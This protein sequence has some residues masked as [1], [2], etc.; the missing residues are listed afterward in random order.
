MIKICMIGTGYVGLVS[1]ACLADFGHHVT[2]VDIDG[3]RIDRLEQGEIPIYEPGLKDVVQ[4]NVE[5]ERLYFTKNLAAAVKDADVVFIAVGTPSAADGSTD[6]TYV[7]EAS[8]DVAKHLAGYT[9]VVQKST[10]PVGT[11]RKVHAI[12]SESK[13]KGTEF[14]VVSNPEFL[15]EGSA[16]GDFLEP[17]RVVIGVASARSA[18]VMREVYRPLYERDT[19]IVITSLESAEMI[20]Y[21]ANAFLATKISFIN[22][23]AHICELAGAN[24]DE[25][26]KG[27]GYDPRIGNKFL[28][29]G[30]G[31]GGS[32][33]PKDVSSLIHCAREH[34]YDAPLVSAAHA[35]NYGLVDRAMEKLVR[36]LGEINGKSIGLLGLAFKPNTDDLREAPALRLVHELLKAGARVKVFDPVAMENFRKLIKAPVEY[37]RNVYEMAEG[38]DALMLVTEWNQFREMDFARLKQAMR[39]DVFIDCRNVYTP[40]R[41]AAR[42]FKYDSFGRGQS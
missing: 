23:M 4:R 34:G 19:P 30:I 28:H 32:C 27:M 38:C 7:L 17:D 31:Y 16:V 12:L 21:A 9:V 15:R 20:K 8:R 37:G 10:A 40:E 3:E 22:E 14:D 41:I 13:P 24:I 36:A 6:L 5:A 29:P 39:G 26:A 1:G 42:G 18:D 25:V 35:I 2:C 11:A 33:L